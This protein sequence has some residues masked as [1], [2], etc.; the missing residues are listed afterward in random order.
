MPISGGRTTLQGFHLGEIDGPQQLG[1]LGSV[2]RGAR[3]H[4]GPHSQEAGAS[5]ETLGAFDG[6]WSLEQRR[7]H[8]S[9]QAY[10]I[11]MNALA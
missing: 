4:C 10:T 11:V 1:N 7:I 5:R 9:A 8:A 2:G 6:R 3:W